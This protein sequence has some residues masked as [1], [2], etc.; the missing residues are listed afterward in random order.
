ME[1]NQTIF[2][3]ERSTQEANQ[4]V[5]HSPEEKPISQPLKKMTKSSERNSPSAVDELL[6]AYQEQAVKEATK[7]PEPTIRVSEVLGSIAFIYERIRNV[8]DYKGEHLLRRNAIERIIKRKIREKPTGEPKE[9]ALSLIRELIWARYLRNDSIPKSKTEAVGKILAKYSLLLKR[10]SGQA[11]DSKYANEW[12]DW[13]LGIASCE[14]EEALAPSLFYITAYV[15]AM[16]RWFKD[17]FEWEGSHLSPQVRDIQIFIA[18]HRSLPKSDEAMIRYHL[19]H[20]FY[21]QWKKADS[22]L[23]DEIAENLPK[24]RE[25]IEDQLRHPVRFNLFRY[26]QKNTAPFQIL[27]DVIDEDPKKAAVLIANPEKFEWKIREVCRRRY[28]QI[29]QKVNRGIIHSIVYIFV[30]KVLFA[31]I[32]E[33][34]YELYFLH[35]LAFIPITINAIIP[36]TLM[37]LIGLTIKTPNEANTERIIERIKSFVYPQ[38]EV[39]TPFSLTPIKRGQFLTTVFSVIYF[40][41]F[42]LV[43]GGIS[44]I[45]FKLKF[46]VVSGMIFFVFL[47]LVLLFGF[48]VRFTASELMV[49][50]EREGLLTHL[51][52]NLSLPFL[53]LGVWLSQGLAQ[54]NVF[55]ILMDFL[56]EAPL[57]TI[58]AIVEEWTSFLRERREEVI[59]VPMQ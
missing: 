56:I 44:L 36:P 29:R 28:S 6:A 48:R 19:L 13:L 57:K 52:N 37:F 55:M 10:V 8:I 53:N 18:I 14:I 50:G 32:L 1:S 7:A 23:L 59:E 42:L 31:F 12:K 39:K 58:I 3:S 45:L 51:F 30:T 34:P 49:T 46:N 9:L 22:Q 43:F 41:L 27:R 2:S 40:L 11:N 47:S 54:L 17:N 33:F 5:L 16:F 25:E 35:R 26:I 24:L 20:L 4:E 38:S 15:Q 21:P